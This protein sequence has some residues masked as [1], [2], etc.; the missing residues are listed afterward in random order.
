M[1]CCEQASQPR[2]SERDTKMITEEIDGFTFFNVRNS[3]EE[4]RRM[5]KDERKQAFREA[6]KAATA[7]AK[8]NGLAVAERGIGMVVSHVPLPECSC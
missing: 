1:V 4:V 7:F 5:S 3:I 6:K 8:K 2:V